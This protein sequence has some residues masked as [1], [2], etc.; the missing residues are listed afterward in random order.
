LTKAADEKEPKIEGIGPVPT[1]RTF[2]QQKAGPTSK[3]KQQ[4]PSPDRAI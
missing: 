3:G 1:E 4:E 2:G